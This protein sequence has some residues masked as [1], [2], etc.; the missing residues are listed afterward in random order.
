M[1]LRINGNVASMAAQRNLAKSTGELQN[2]YQ[3]LSSGLRISKAADDAAGLAI[4]ERMRSRITSLGQASRNSQDG[5]SMVQTAE[6]SLNEISSILGRMR[7]LSVQAQNDTYSN[8]DKDAID[9][10]LQQLVD[11]VDRI[12]QSSKFNGT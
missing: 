10:E 7:E 6:G 11:E 9:Q 3:K 2:S 4:S 12:A 1:P 5:I 8:N